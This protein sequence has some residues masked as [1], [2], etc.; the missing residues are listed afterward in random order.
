MKFNANHGIILRVIGQ[1]LERKGIASFD[2]EIQGEDVWVS[3]G[4]NP[5]GRK[6]PKLHVAHSFKR[7]GLGKS[8]KTRCREAKAPPSQDSVAFQ[9]HYTIEELKRLDQE[10]RVKR[11]DPDRIPSGYGMSEILRAVGIF[12]GH[13]KGRLHSLSLRHGMVTIAYDTTA[14]RRT[15]DLFAAPKGAGVGRKNK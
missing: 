13:E 14:G 10:A 6:S 7:S 3:I 9:Q 4:A 15:V 8:S 5:P 11:R 1:D 12:V 2:M